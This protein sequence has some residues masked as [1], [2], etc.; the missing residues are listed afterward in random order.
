MASVNNM[1]SKEV[2]APAVVQSPTFLLDRSE[3]SEGQDKTELAHVY[4]KDY[5]ITSI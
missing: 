3:Y 4:I 5:N 1:H 2:S